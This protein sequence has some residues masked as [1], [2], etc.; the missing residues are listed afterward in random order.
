[1]R[2]ILEKE[3]DGTKAI[4]A[5]DAV[6]TGKGSSIAEDYPLFGA[7]NAATKTL[8]GTGGYP[9]AAK[10]PG[11]KIETLAD[12]AAGITSGLS[13]FAYRTTLDAPSRVSVETDATRNAGVAVPIVSGKPDL[14]HAAKL[15]ANLE[16]DVLVVVAGITSKKT[17]APFTVHIGAADPAITPDAGTSSSSSS[18]AD[19]GGGGCATTPSSLDAHAS[20]AFAA[21]AMTLAGLVVTRRRRR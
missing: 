19:G 20:S 14:A 1:V 5:T 12:G 4:A 18:G 9:D 6:L 10:Y 13:Y 21:M 8:A 7:W 3:I 16:G 15:P 17:D 11:V 2:E